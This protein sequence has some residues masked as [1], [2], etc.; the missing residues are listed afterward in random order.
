MLDNQ[1]NILLSPSP[2][3]K[4][5][6][7]GT[8]NFLFGDNEDRDEA[9][10][11]AADSEKAIN[12][13]QSDLKDID[14][15]NPFADVS[16]AFQGLTNAYEGADNVYDKAENV[17]EG[18]MVN[19]FE[20]QKNAFEG[21]K[22]QMEGMENAF[23]DLTVNTQQAEF[24]AQQNQQMQ[25]N[26]MSQMSGA[27][28]GSGIAALA[29][30]MANQGA[31]QAQKA[32]ASIGAQE[33]A[34]M[35]KAAEAEQTINLKTADEASRIANAQA[36]EQS[37]LDTQK[38]M[39][40]ME[41][42]NKIL[43]ADEALQNQKLGEAS[44]LQM[45]EMGADMQLQMA[46]AQGEMDVQS[47]QA[48]GD[49]WSKE[50]ELGKHK[51]AMEVEMSKYSAAAAEAGAPKDR[52]L[53]GNLFSD[54][55]LKENI[56]KIG[57]SHNHI[58]L[59]KFNYIGDEATY[60]G[61]MAQD[62][63]K[64]G[65]DN[66]VGKQ[67]GFY[68]VNYNLIDIN[69]VK[70]SSPLKQLSGQAQERAQDD[71]Q[72]QGKGTMDAGM[73]ILSE[74]QKRKNWEELQKLARSSEPEEMQIRKHKDRILR[75]N[76]RDMLGPKGIIEAPGV[77]G[78]ANSGVYM[79]ALVA[80][81]KRFQDLLYK[82]VQK[83]DKEA[84]QDINTRVATIKRL[85][86][87][88]REETQ[89]Y[90]ENHFAPSSYLSK[91]VSQQKSSI[92]TQLY[93]N[94]PEANIVFAEKRDVENGTTDFYGKTVV[95]GTAY[96]LCYDFEGEAI[97][98]NILEGNK[99]MW[100]TN[101]DKAVEYLGFLT[102][103][104]RDASE[105]AAKKEVS[106]IKPVLGRINFKMDSMFGNNDGTATLKQ[107]QLVMQFCWDEH[108]LK[109]G[110]SFRR[111]LYEHPNI[112]N[113]NYG[114]FDWDAMEFSRPLAEGDKEYWTDNID[115]FDQI[116]LV[117]AITNQDHPS[118]DIDLLRTLI[119]EYYAYKIENAWWKGMGFDEGKLTVM[120][121][122]Q[123][124]MIKIRFEKE[125][126]K[127]ASDGKVDFTFDGKVYPTGLDIKKVKKEEA[128]QNKKMKEGIAKAQKQ[129]PN[130]Q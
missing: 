11:K 2:L 106:D 49:K 125:K 82:A 76:Q 107:N 72:M 73:D 119:K 1:K 121:L 95:E 13:M 81:C 60:V 50:M 41:I 7:K 14:T 62:L 126:A 44:K 67:D 34:N 47:M 65:M 108:I 12:Q 130:I 87:R 5:A 90:M 93:C 123:K 59:Y 21:M 57:T 42:Q 39:A 9:K 33:S 104:H 86:D 98:V 55:R 114:G 30:S 52:G 80:E 45:A 100:W 103:V 83:G 75:Q 25:A 4:K 29:Q 118:Y 63:I 92:A 48:E 3:K 18:K 88:Y 36:S 10:S 111:H 69:M 127:A 38:N 35:A 28:G 24:E 122:K 78:V 40:D 84:E 23:E 116:A 56:T 120:R 53:L 112:Q 124:E 37:R 6:W 128:I 54:E 31:L 115:P 94:N 117:D 129:K 27:A 43:G 91:G 74:A 46:E 58:P 22:N 20:G 77:D 51:T 105:A 15:S 79:K 32:S 19:P 26:I 8:K 101:M 97:M 70:L 71:K 89:E 61:T 17:Y 16:N 96:A 66:A 85:S 68:T 102:E 64:L 113:L 109:D 110:S 99:E